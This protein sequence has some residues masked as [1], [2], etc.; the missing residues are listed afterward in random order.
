MNGKYCIKPRWYRGVLNSN[1][2]H[3]KRQSSHG[4]ADN[5]MSSVSCK[6]GMVADSSKQ[7]TRKTKEQPQIYEQGK[8]LVA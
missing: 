2:A 3:G 8:S 7:F 5:V 6:V 1:L 4:F